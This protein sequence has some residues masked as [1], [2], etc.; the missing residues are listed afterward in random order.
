MAFPVTECVITSSSDIILSATAFYSSYKLFKNHRA[1]SVGLFLLGLSAALCILL[2]C[3][4]YLTSIKRE[5]EWAGE[6]FAPVLFAFDFLWLSEDHNTAYIL[7]CGSCLLLGVSDWL[8]AD[9]LALMTR[10][11]GLS[12]LSCCLMVCLFASNA[13]GAFGGVA[14]SLPLLLAQNVRAN[15]VAPLIYPAATEGLIKGLLKASMAVGCW[16]ST[17]A[18]SRFRLDVTDQCN[19]DF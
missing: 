12:S 17:Q 7:L 2:P 13:L 6:V 9:A 14:L 19:V 8:S 5:T 10:C 15:T 4:P 16:V 11:L 3:S 18:I 1:P